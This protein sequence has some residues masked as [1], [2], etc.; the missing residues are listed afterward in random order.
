GHSK[1]ERI[2]FLTQKEK[3]PPKSKTGIV[4]GVVVALLILSAVA[5]FLIWFSVKDAD[6]DAALSKQLRQSVPVF[7]GHM[8][9]VNQ[10]YDQN[11]EDTNSPEFQA[12]A[13]KLET[14]DPILEKYYTKSV[15][16]AFEGVKAYYWSQ[17]NIP[18]SDLEMIPEVS[19]ERILNALETDSRM[20]RDPR[21]DH[22]FYRL[23][24]DTNPQNFS[25]PGY[26]TGYPPQSRCQWQI[27][28][29]EEN[30][31]VVNF[32]YFYIEDDCSDDFVYIY[33]S[34]SPDDS[35]AITKCGQRPPSNPLEVVSSNNIMLIN[36]IAETDA[37]KPGF[38][39]VYSVIPKADVTCGGSLSQKQGS[40]TSPLY[41]SFYPP[42][43]E[44]KWTI[45]APGSKVRL[46]F[47]MFR[48]KEPGV[49]TR[50][51]HKDYVEIMGNYCGEVA[52][53]SL[54]SDT[55][56]LVVN[57]HSDRS[58][59]D[60]G[61]SAEY[62][63]YDPS[64]CPDRFACTNGLCID[65]KLKC[66]GWNDCGDMSDESRC[67][68]KDQFACSNG[69]CKPKLWVC[70]HVN[71]CGDES[72]E[73]MCCALNEFQCG[74]GVC[75]PQ[76]VK[77]DDKQDCKDG[78]D[79]VGCKTICTD[80]SFKC[81][82]GVC[83]NKVNAECDRVQDCSDNSD[84]TICCGTRPYKLNRIVGGQ[85]AE[86]GE[87][88]WQVSLHFSTNGPTCGASIISNTWLLSAAHCFR[89]KDPSKWQSYSGMQNQF[90]HDNVQS[91]KLKR[92]IPHPL[93]NQMTSDYDIALL[94]LSEPLQ[95]ANTIQPIC[96]PDSSHVF[97]AGM[98]CW[99]TGWGALRE[100]QAAQI[101]QKALVKIINDSV[102]DVVTEGQVTSRMLCSGY[103]SGG[104]D[105]CQQGDSGG[106]LACFEESGKWFQAGIVSWGE[107]CARRNKPGVYTRVT[108][109][110]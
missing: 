78:S 30:V 107:G 35:Q 96:L 93:Y 52:S 53:L 65:Q 33:D 56:V 42:A 60:K 6:S 71:D 75:L 21:A 17:F 70:D 15:V 99:V 88:P 97:P 101:L 49:D 28:A 84:E 38:Q 58:H 51:C 1:H 34:L 55:N 5:A 57:F 110:R 22:C 25:S 27:R 20:A 59:T 43:K 100:G 89:N 47:T 19:E 66:D 102:C 13:E 9:L 94:E 67:C 63:S 48:M 14:R 85:N 3:A 95:F 87:W 8:T 105:A 104:V 72:D 11:L 23:E 98:S 32:L 31:I 62:S 26:P 37:Q 82:S 90:S 7:S 103:L 61:F 2:D 91:R 79:E 106:P 80:Y 69:M 108:K 81:K 54:T 74:N 45:T 46:R 18:N 76:S 36:F 29:S 41:P 50:L 12:L 83:I 92:I 73:K 24:A 109:L 86:L 16:T 10:P 68:D 40:F 77:C 64:N 39:A 4:I 44:C